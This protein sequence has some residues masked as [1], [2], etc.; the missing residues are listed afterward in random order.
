MK[1]IIS[2]ALA[3]I[4]LAVPLILSSC[5]GGLDDLK[6]ELE[7]KLEGNYE[8][9]LAGTTLYVY[10]W[11]EYIS[12]GEDDSLDI[13]AAF[14]AVTGIRVEYST[15]DSN[16]AMYATISGGG[17]EYDI[18]IPSDYMVARLIAEDRL[19]KIDFSKLQNYK[20]IDEKYKN[21]EYD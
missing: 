21:P 20:Y 12:D 15:Y 9:D 14:E 2:L 3:A 4:V 11:G 7:G 5:S 8:N 13:N 1:R 6:T 18:V 10:N 17:V 19:E 16:E